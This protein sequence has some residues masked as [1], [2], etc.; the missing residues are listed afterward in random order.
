MTLENMRE[1]PGRASS[2]TRRG[3]RCQPGRSPCAA[4]T[5]GGSCARRERS[6]AGSSLRGDTPGSA[7]HSPWCLGASHTDSTQSHQR[8]PKELSFLMGWYDS[9]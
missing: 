8:N 6:G 9:S 3:G 7:T 2:G 5:Q 1:V 4:G